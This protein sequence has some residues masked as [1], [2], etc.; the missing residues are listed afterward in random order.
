MGGTRNNNIS[1]VFDPSQ[2]PY[3][4]SKQGIHYQ[5]KAYRLQSYGGE[6]FAGA[7]SIYKSLLRSTILSFEP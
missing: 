4:V 5:T 1:M 2:G 6:R 3:E 7:V